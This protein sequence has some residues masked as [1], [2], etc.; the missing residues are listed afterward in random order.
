[1]PKRAF[2]LIEL[3]V[4]IAIIA[5][6]IGLLLPAVQKVRDAANRA[7]CQSN[8]KQLVIA[9][10]A[11]HGDHMAFP[12]GLSQTA[13]PSQYESEISGAGIA[14]SFFG[15]SVFSYLLP[16]VEGGNVITDG[17]WH[18]TDPDNG[19][20]N[21]SGILVFDNAR[22]SGSISQSAPTAAVIKVFLC[23]GD[24]FTENPVYLSV[25]ISGDGDE[26]DLALM[27]GWYGLTSY[28][29]NAGTKFLPV[30]EVAEGLADGIYFLTG[31]AS[32][33]TKNQ[34]PV[35]IEQITDG[36]STTLMFGERY[37][38][39]PVF[40]KTQN[41]FNIYPIESWGAWGWNG[42]PWAASHVLNGTNSFT[43]S[44]GPFNKGDAIPINFTL[45]QIPYG[46]I[47]DNDNFVINRLGAWG[48]GHSSGANFA[49]CD[50]SVK[51]IATTV[52][53]TILKA[54]S[55]RAGGEPIGDY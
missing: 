32:L 8:M 26:D 11:Y 52:D 42:G 55:T 40:D 19:V 6:L 31:T 2:T 49:M 35:N 53:Y 44:M 15:S 30:D 13:V 39:D 28:L 37:H 21:G 4:V 23:P 27:Q 12:P 20:G 46:D 50:G 16:Y 33:P 41:Q 22:S 17:G 43:A 36:L 7:A 48:S 24:G 51:F 1:M 9:A 10:Q 47:T 34:S 29:G 38:S 3:L 54:L 45:A 18:Y 14:S 5:I 25:N